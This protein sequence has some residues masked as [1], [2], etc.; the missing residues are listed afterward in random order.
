VVRHV[1]AAARA[2]RGIPSSA[3][4][5]IAIALAAGVVCTRPFAAG[6]EDTVTTPYEGVRHIKRITATPNRIHIVEVDLTNP[7]IRLRATRS[8][9]RQRVVSSFADLYGCQIAT[10]GDF[11]SYTDYS[12]SGLAVG[13]GEKWSDT[14]DNSTQGFIGFGRA[15]EV[16]ISLPSSVDTPADWMEDVV[17]GRPMVVKDGAAV[18]FSPCTDSFCVRNPRTAVGFNEAHSKMWLVVVD[19][20]SSS[21]VGMSLNELGQLMKGLGAHRA[22]NLDGGGSSTMYI[23]AQGGVQNAPSDGAQRVVANHLGVCIVKPFGTL[24]GYIRKYDI[25]DESAGMAGVTVM[26]SSG[27]SAVTDGDGLYQIAEVPRGDVT[28]TAAA[29]GFAG[30][31]AVYVTADDLT[32]GSIPMSEDTGGDDDGDSEPGSDAGID[33]DSTGAAGDMGGGC[34]ST[35]TGAGAGGALLLMVLALLPRRRG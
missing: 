24:R 15:N 6:A 28:I 20:R 21:S 30:E 12:T 34:S 32:W 18:T 13:H 14:K 9:H 4:L 16:G 22:L 27:Q 29:D 23:K 35:G 7:T 26:L 17:G 8:Q 2:M 1:Q 31:R 5:R 10:N 3:R 19:G 25:M 33:D 11:F